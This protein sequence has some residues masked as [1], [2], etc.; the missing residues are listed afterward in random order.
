MRTG[1]ELALNAMKKEY[2]L[3]SRKADKAKKEADEYMSVG[4]E[5]IAIHNEFVKIVKAKDHGEEVLKKLD[6]L[7][8]RSEKA[9]KIRKKDLV[10]LIDKESETRFTADS[11]SHE[12][13]NL[14]FRLSLRKT[15]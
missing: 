10:K 11:L 8:K 13:Q 1:E 7:K 12:I 15:G 4:T 5:L 14:E 6:V 9:E 2:T 3:L